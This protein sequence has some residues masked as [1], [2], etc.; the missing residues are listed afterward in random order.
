MVRAVS[1][2]VLFCGL[3][4]LG[5]ACSGKMLTEGDD[6]DDSISPVQKCETYAS[7]WCNKAFGCYVKVGRMKESD[8][9]GNVNK[10]VQIIVDRLPCS[11][12]SSVTDDYDECISQI[13][14]MSCSR[15]DVP[16]T[17]F[18]TITP[19]TS[20]DTALSF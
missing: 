13:D 2:V 8:R 9:Q 7:T 4:L 6:D 20:C 19:P 14:G 3:V 18:G 5:G 11:E 10:C 15:W 12:I 1:A 16:T 17:Q